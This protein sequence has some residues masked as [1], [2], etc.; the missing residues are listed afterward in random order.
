MLCS[1]LDY[2]LD[3][4]SW[5]WL[6][7]GLDAK[8]KGATLF[9]KADWPFWFLT[10]TGVIQKV[11]EHYTK[12]SL[13]KELLSIFCKAAP[14]SIKCTQGCVRVN[15][16]QLHGGFIYDPTTRHTPLLFIKWMAF[17]KHHFQLTAAPPLNP[18][19]R[20]P[21]GTPAFLKMFVFIAWGS[22]ASW[23]HVCQY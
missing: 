12:E 8:N 18:D 5:F 23:D 10:V 3:M 11:L 4:Q 6:V 21:T 9:S 20:Y 22:R 16:R 13:G 1:A 15:C 2:W 7:G 14:K 17:S 19:F